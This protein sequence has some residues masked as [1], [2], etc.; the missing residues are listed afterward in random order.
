MTDTGSNRHP[1]EV[2]AADFVERYRRGE[3]PALT[4]YTTRH[5]DLAEQIRSLFP[6]VVMMEDLKR[7]RVHGAG[8]P[9]DARGRV[10][11]ILGDCRIVREVGRGGM[12]VVYEA[13]QESLGR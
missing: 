2:L 10:P 13:E 6:A 8:Y 3:R 9:F 12:G 1:L 5:P 4:E 7:T 11:D